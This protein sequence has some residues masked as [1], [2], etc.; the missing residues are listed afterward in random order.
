MHQTTLVSHSASAPSE[1]KI[2]IGAHLFHRSPAGISSFT[3]WISSSQLLHQEKPL[4]AQ[5]LSCRARHEK[6]CKSAELNAP[7]YVMSTQTLRPDFKPVR[8]EW[9]ISE[10]SMVIGA[11]WLYLW[12]DL[13]VWKTK[14]GP[15]ATTKQ[16][17][18]NSKKWNRS[19][20][21]AVPSGTA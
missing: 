17:K 9:F 8:C 1:K 4:W 19:K 6:I 21:G 14:L 13:R 18:V 15:C 11:V 10:W 3:G 12:H 16:I 20:S 2:I 5:R 7:S